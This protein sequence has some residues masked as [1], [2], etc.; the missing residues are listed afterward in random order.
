VRSLG[1]LS[2]EVGSGDCLLVSHHLPVVSR[3][4]AAPYLALL[5]DVNREPQRISER[6]RCAGLWLAV[7]EDTSLRMMLFGN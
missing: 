2:F 5:F 4:V 6:V 1:E 3:V 7:S